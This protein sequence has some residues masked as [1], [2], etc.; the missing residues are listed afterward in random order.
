ML[1]SGRDVFKMRKSTAKV[2]FGPKKNSFRAQRAI[3]DLCVRVKRQVVQQCINIFKYIT[4]C[5]TLDQ[6]AI[7]RSH[8]DVF[9]LNQQLYLIITALQQ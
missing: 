2:T 1:V 7:Y 4:L 6:Q 3:E 9:I 5:K 8:N